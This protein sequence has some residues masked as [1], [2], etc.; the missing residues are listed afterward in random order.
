MCIGELHFSNLKVSRTL[1]FMFAHEV[2]VSVT[3]QFR[4]IRK[5]I[6]HDG[7]APKQCR[8]GRNVG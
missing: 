1:V 7:E 6:T 4:G 2:K 5:I 8:K 3:I